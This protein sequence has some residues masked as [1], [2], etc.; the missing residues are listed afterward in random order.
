M[1]AMSG[2]ILAH[3]GGWDEFLMVGVPIVIVAV[4]LFVANRRAKT[5]LG[6]QAPGTSPD[7]ET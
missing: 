7:D 4:L 1:G 5:A 3:Q 6:D 2:V